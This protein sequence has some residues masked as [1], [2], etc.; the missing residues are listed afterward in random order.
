MVIEYHIPNGKMRID[1]EPFFRDAGIR[2]IR[3][4]MKQLS[5]SWPES[6]EYPAEIRAYLRKRIQEEKARAVDYAGKYMDRSSKLSELK[7]RYDEM[8][9]P[10]YAIYTKD[11]GVLSRV[12]EEIRACKA[13]V[14]DAKNRMIKAQKLADKYGDI[15]EDVDKILGG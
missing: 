2:Q 12:K 5:Q 1:V 6:R 3:R 9:S 15:L 7:T 11:K 10:C 14:T 13:K 8:K 4:M